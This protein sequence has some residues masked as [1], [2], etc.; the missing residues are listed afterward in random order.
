MKIAIEYSG[1]LRFIQETFP[2]IKEY[3]IA[4]EDCEFFFFFHTWDE[5]LPED[6]VYLKNTIKPHRFLIDKQKSFERH[7]YQLMNTDMTHDE[8]RK[9]SI[10]WNSEHPP[11][12]QKAFFEKPDIANGYKFDKELE[13]V[14]FPNYSHYPFNTLSLFYSMHQVSVL[15]NSYAQEHNIEF[16]FVIRMRSDLQLS[17]P[18]NLSEIT[19]K[20]SIYLFDALPHMGH[21]GKYT[22]HD[23]FA[24]GNPRNMTIYNDLFIYLPCYYAVFKIDWISEILL[25]FHLQYNQI[26]TIKIPRDYVLLRYP[27]RSSVDIGRPTH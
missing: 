5:S 12:G 16:D 4:D 7:P 1:H 15:G 18:I 25:G 27:E 17:T 23:Q 22:I 8:Y 9:E 10:K 20:T 14:R 24:I 6:I 21:F 19:D 26:K 11:A 13:V 3:L 2:K